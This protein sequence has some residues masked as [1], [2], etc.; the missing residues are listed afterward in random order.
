[1]PA[2]VQIRSLLLFTYFGAGSG[3]SASNPAQLLALIVTRKRKR[4]T[5]S[6]TP[7]LFH[8]T[9][10]NAC[11]SQDFYCTSILTVALRTLT[12]QADFI[13]LRTKGLLTIFQDFSAK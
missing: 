9:W 3:G 6:A 5:K 2:D 12:L 8:V 1:M 10:V 4:P 11:N 7:E 13:F